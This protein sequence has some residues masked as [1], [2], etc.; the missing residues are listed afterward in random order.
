MKLYLVGRFFSIN[1]KN[2]CFWDLVG[3]FDN[4]KMAVAACVGDNYFY[5]DEVKLNAPDKTPDIIKEFKRAIYP[6]LLSK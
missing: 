3:I 5:T 6:N 4:K 1:K 2:E